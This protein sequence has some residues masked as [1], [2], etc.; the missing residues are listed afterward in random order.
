MTKIIEEDANR[1]D[2]QEILPN[3]FDWIDSRIAE[4]RKGKCL[5]TDEQCRYIER[6]LREK[7]QLRELPKSEQ[8]AIGKDLLAEC[9]PKPAEQP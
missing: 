6:L 3:Q 8:L 5:I 4:A 9:T 1:R 2:V 7:L